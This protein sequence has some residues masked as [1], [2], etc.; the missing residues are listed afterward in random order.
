MGAFGVSSADT[1]S[2]LTQETAFASGC[3][4]GLETATPTTTYRAGIC[5]ETS[6]REGRTAAASTVSRARPTTGSRQVYSEVNC[7]AGFRL[8]QTTDAATARD[9]ALW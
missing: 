2:D 8:C 4:A 9:S 3:R 1:G 7:A 5:A 6:T